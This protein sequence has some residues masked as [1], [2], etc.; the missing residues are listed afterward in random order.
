MPAG[1]SQTSKLQGTAVQQQMVQQL[2][3]V[4]AAAVGVLLRQQTA[5]HW[6]PTQQSTC[7]K[8]YVGQAGLA[9]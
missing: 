8:R 3:Q 6:C 2:Q 5:V 9:V 7:T 1:G 4:A